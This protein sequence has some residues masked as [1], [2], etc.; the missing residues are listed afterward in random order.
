MGSIRAAMRSHMDPFH[1]SFGWGF[2]LGGSC[3]VPVGPQRGLFHWGEGDASSMQGVEVWKCVCVSCLAA[4]ENRACVCVAYND[5]EQKAQVRDAVWKDMPDLLAALWCT[6]L[7]CNPKLLW[8]NAGL[9]VCLPR[10]KNFLDSHPFQRKY[11]IRP[12]YIYNAHKQ[13]NP[14]TLHVPLHSSSLLFPLNTV[15]AVAQDNVSNC[16][17]DKPNYLS[18]DCENL[19]STLTIKP[20]EKH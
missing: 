2:V 1:N 3:A 14:V 12:I 10:S 17:D 4:C 11:Y 19:W 15:W 5:C 9:C 7:L 16:L 8:T 18:E 13:T 20:E 6:P